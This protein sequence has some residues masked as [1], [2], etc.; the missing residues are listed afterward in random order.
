MADGRAAS[1]PSPERPARSMPDSSNF[2]SR[3]VARRKLLLGAG[4]ALALGLTV[5]C[6]SG[7]GASS[8]RG[9]APTGRTTTRGAAAGQPRRPPERLWIITDD[10]PAGPSGRCR[11]EG[12]A[13]RAGV[14]FAQGYV[15]VPG[16]APPGR[17]CR[18]GRTRTT[19]GATPTRPTSLR[20]QGLEQDTV[21]TR[22]GAA[23]YVNGYFGKYMNGHGWSRST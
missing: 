9:G 1:G 16:A 13:G 3:P 14:Q 15:A 6:S 22:M 23:G 20:R 7:A 2:P 10:R 19:T 18:P 11:H 12:A 21:A 17:R 5:A 8:E 4:G